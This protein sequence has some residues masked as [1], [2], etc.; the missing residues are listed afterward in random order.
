MDLLSILLFATNSILPVILL[1]ALG[2]FLKTRGFFTGEFLRIGNKTVFRVLLPV[3]LFTNLAELDSF[4]ELKWDAVLYV[5]AVVAL[6]FALGL[7]FAGM[8]PD[9]R[10]KGVLLQGDYFIRI[11]GNSGSEEMP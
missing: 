8:T 7:L 1:A 3:L 4:S 9:R 5:L 6:L 11:P 10:Q 2:Y